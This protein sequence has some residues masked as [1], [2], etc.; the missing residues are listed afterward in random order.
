MSMLPRMIQVI[1]RVI[2]AAI[3]S[4]PL[5]VRVNMGSVRMSSL[6]AIIGFARAAHLGPEDDFL[7]RRTAEPGP[8]CRHDFLGGQ[9]FEL[10][11]VPD[12]ERGCIPHQL[13]DRRHG[14]SRRLFPDR[15]VEQ[16]RRQRTARSLQEARQFSSY[17]PLLIWIPLLCLLIRC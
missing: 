16:K 11:P 13:F 6:V 12:H 5:T 2:T 4:D 17:Q 9:A 8:G 15:C 3:V 14:L 10:E 7:A 1:A